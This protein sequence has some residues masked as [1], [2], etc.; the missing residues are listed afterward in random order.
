MCEVF[1]RVRQALPR[2]LLR[3][4]AHESCGKCTPCR[5]GTWWVV[6]ILDRLESG[7]GRMEDM[8]LLADVGDN[9]L[10]KAFCALADGAVSPI[11]STLKY[12]GD[13]YE[14]HVRERRCPFSDRPP[15][16]GPDEPAEEPVPV[17]REGAA[18]PAFIPLSEVLR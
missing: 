15:V 7:Y 3:F 8:P 16:A 12:F 14:A 6:R 10:F 13:E 9:I 11:S 2:R 18:E 4:Y 5:E 1:A 17:E